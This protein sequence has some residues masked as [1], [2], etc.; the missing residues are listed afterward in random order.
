MVEF[1][2]HANF[3]EEP[4]LLNSLVQRKPQEHPFD[5][6]ARV[7]YSV[8]RRVNIAEPAFSYLLDLCKQAVK[9]PRFEQV[10]L[11]VLSKAPLW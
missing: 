10:Y 5:S 1:P 7:F 9:L 2:Q 11:W 4:V 6:V 3:P 8:D